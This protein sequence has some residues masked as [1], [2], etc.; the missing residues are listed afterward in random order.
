[1]TVT[2]KQGYFGGGDHPHV[3]A[4]VRIVYFSIP[5]GCHVIDGKLYRIADDWETLQRITYPDGSHPTACAFVPVD[6]PV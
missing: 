3:P 4:R 1:M 6:E 2:E 5:E